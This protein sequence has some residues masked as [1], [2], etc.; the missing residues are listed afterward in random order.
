MGANGDNG[1]ASFYARLEYDADYAIR[2]NSL[3]GEKIG[4]LP[5]C[6]N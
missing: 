3:D 1:K 4:W 2:R 6:S 5:I